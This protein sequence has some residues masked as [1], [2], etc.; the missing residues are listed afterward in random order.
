MD[1][2]QQTMEKIVLTYFE[3]RNSKMK[4]DKYLRT[5]ERLVIDY[6][7]TSAYEG[8]KKRKGKTNG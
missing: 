5:I 2:S 3:Y 4:L 6:T 8:Y 1:K 7:L